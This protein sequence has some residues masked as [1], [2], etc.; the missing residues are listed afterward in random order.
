M[1]KAQKQKAEDFVKTLSQAHDELKKLMERNSTEAINIALV[2]LEDCQQGA[3]ELGNMIEKSEGE[4]FE[5][6]RMLE[7]YCEL[8]YKIHCYLSEEGMAEPSYVNRAYRNLRKILVQ[9]E[10]S[11]HNNIRVC[12]EVVFF[13]YKAS[14]WDSFESVWRS[15]EEDKD[16]DACVV[17]IPYYD[18]NPDGS[19]REMHYEGG[20]YPDYVPVTSYKDYDLAEHHPDII[21][22]HNPY[23]EFNYVTS[24]HPLYYAKN[25][26]QFTDELIYI[27]YFILDEIDPDDQPAIDGM[28]HFVWTSGVIHADKVIVQSE[29][30]KQIYVNEYLKKAKITGMQGQHIDR[31][32]LENKILG[33]GSPKVHKVLNTKKNDL[34]IPDEWLKVI[35]KPDGSWKKIV[36]YNTSI[37]ALLQHDERMLK[38]MECVFEIFYENRED[39]ALLWRPHPLIESTLI[40]MRPQL[41]ES[42]KIIR[43]KYIEENW[44]IYDDT[45]DMDRAVILSD[46]YY[47]DESSV[48]QLYKKTEKPHM[49]QDVETF[50]QKDHVLPISNAVVYKNNLWF[51]GLNDNRIYRMDIKTFQA[52]VE[53]RIPWEKLSVKKLQYSKVVLYKCKLILI[54]G[55]ASKITVY[56]LERKEIRYIDYHD[57]KCGTGAFFMDGVLENNELYLI[58]TSYDR[59]VCIDAEKEKVIKR[60]PSLIETANQEKDKRAYAFA[61]IAKENNY[62]LFTMTL[63]N[64]VIKYNMQSNNVEILKMD[65]LYDGGNGI[66][67]DFENIWIIH[68]LQKKIERYHKKT[69]KI[70]I[71]EQFPAEFIGG[72]WNFHQ[73]YLNRNDLILLPRDSNMCL[74]I[75]AHSN[76]AEQI[77]LENHINKTGCYWD[78]MYYTSIFQMG[79]KLMISD[80]KGYIYIYYPEGKMEK[81]KIEIIDEDIAPEFS[82]QFDYEENN[83]WESLECFL[84]F[85]LRIWG[86][87]EKLSNSSMFADAENQIWEEIA[88]G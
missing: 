66:L 84:N 20:L 52:T 8:A 73:A 82:Q 81:R 49:I 1:R 80:Y 15:V 74:K 18:K 76:K 58:P 62:I 51:V 25:L 56:D 36:F 83:K 75:Y 41:W 9:I 19:F 16:C 79:D 43:D 34:V 21:F 65:S 64:K 6:I 85:I 33:L 50:R 54:P 13:P 70:T 59:V 42:Y 67:S 28:K 45:S 88:Q 48:L 35:Q 30:M 3:I 26:K 37:T 69:K 72:E 10:N 38:K 40:S 24:V 12:R 57:K 27:P 60:S 31:A 14:M 44:G 87:S 17:P 86:N 23:D 47:G 53:C 63:D 32:Y 2:I 39:I 29:K 61:G 11:I 22:I 7:E 68:K 4:G 71:I 46:A 55:L 78:R 77:K 5:T